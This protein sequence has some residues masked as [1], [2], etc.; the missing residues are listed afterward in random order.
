[1]FYVTVNVAPGMR[2]KV[3]VWA[4]QAGAGLV[5]L[6]YGGWADKTPHTV[7]PH[8]KFENEVDAM[9]Y[10]LAHGGEYS[11]TIPVYNREVVF[12]WESTNQQT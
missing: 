12:S 2:L 3:A 6:C 8:L 9:A 4:E 1:M 5:E 10:I 7:L 11:N